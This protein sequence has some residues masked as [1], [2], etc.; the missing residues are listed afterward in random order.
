MLPA[1]AD[2]AARPLATPPSLQ[3]PSRTLRRAQLARVRAEAEAD[4]PLA[5]EA[6]AELD[7]P[8]SEASRKRAEAERLRAAEKFMVV[9]TGEASC[10]NCGYEYKPAKGDPEYP[11]S[12]GT[13][14]QVRAAAAAHRGG[15]WRAGQAAATPVWHWRRAP[16]PAP[17]GPACAGPR[18]CVC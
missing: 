2:A 8:E 3:A 16:L 13:Q 5:A 18:R 15:L 17:P 1:A 14:F 12:P 6:G 10:K 7:N 9:G 11:V 4:K